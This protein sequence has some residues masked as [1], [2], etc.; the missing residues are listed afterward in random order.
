MKKSKK[1]LVAVS[2]G[3][4]LA[5]TLAACDN[6][7]GAS[8][9]PSG[10]SDG[11][12]Q[13]S[14]DG[15]VE[16]AN[17]T[18]RSYTSALATN[19]NP[20]AWETNA[21]S[22]ALSYLEEGFVSLQP[23]DTEK[24]IY[25]WAYDAATSIKDVT[26]DNAAK[27]A[28]YGIFDSTEAAQEYID[29]LDENDPGRYIYE[30]SLRD[31]LKWQDGTAI[32][33]Q[34]YID[35]MKYLLEPNSKNYRAN[36]Y[37]SGESAIA[38]GAD[39]YYQGSTVPLENYDGSDFIYVSS[40]DDIELKDGKYVSKE[41]GGTVYLAIDSSLTY[42]S[43][44]SLLD[45]VDSY[46]DEMFDTATF[47]QLAALANDDGL[48][49]L[50]TTSLA[51]MK[52][53]LNNSPEW[54]EDGSYW[55]CYAYVDVTYAAA[56][57][58]SVGIYKVDD[59]TFC[60]VMNTPLDESQTFV[61]FQETW[62]VHTE[63]Y[64]KLLDKSKTPWTST[65]GT[66][67]AT[68]MSYGPYKLTSLEA[69]KQMV[70]ETN[71]NWHGYEKVN[72][73]LVSYTNFEVDGAKVR[74]YQTTKVVI[75]QMDDAAAKQQFLKGQLTEYAPTS[76]ELSE[77]TLSDALYQVDE[78]Y[79]MSLF[80]NTNVEALQQMDKSEGNTNSV[81]LSSTNFRKAFSLGIDRAK[82]VTATPAY[83]PAYSLMN[84]LYYYDVW[85]DP[86]SSYRGSEPAMQAIVDL[87]GVEY[88][89]GKA[90]KTLEEAYNSING[91]NLTEAKKLM[92]S[93]CE[94]LV[95]AGLYT[96]GES[97]TIKMAYAK[98]A[99]QSDEQAQIAL[100]NQFINAA[101]EGSGFGAITLEGVGNLSD[102]YA[103]VPQG[104]YAIGYGAWGGAA[105]YPFR[106]MQVYCDPDSYDINEAADWNPKSETLTIEFDY[107]G[108]HFSDTMTWQ[109]WS[110]CLVGNGK[111]ATADNEIKL[112]ITATME[113]EFLGKYYRIPLCGSTSAFLLGYQV[114]YITE[115]YNIMY[116]FGGFR[117]MKYNYTDAEW[118]KYVSDNGG[119]IDYK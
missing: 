73:Q 101:A 106:N 44:Y 3:F 92:K 85:N 74:Q 100:L 17:Y 56:S 89:D 53:F 12:S 86:N 2:L 87:Y 67:V 13:S 104:K 115:N 24:G 47:D 23:S 102:R 80:F 52:T 75:N 99:L 77:Y 10:S 79:T 31:D 76:S 108:E 34:S 110:N 105:F 7:G 20:C 16:A 117:L 119:N 118:D 18:Y 28:Q 63:L 57:F 8:S 62:L 21:D 60:Y 68:T 58:D 83:K 61:S 48:V 29:G 81:V 88:G 97:I 38:G 32:N 15:T 1:S 39:Y 35:S 26:K 66:S 19:W 72:G 51:L 33:A 25:Q 71:E 5:T 6:G 78:T 46:G 69:E 109:A 43:G 37:V 65:Y 114:S 84:N 116:D 94:E 82:Y 54:G 91:Y 107:N 55:V 50:T 14:S 36:L 4:I 27:L 112:R 9:T 42:L 30:I 45:Y 93:A 22:S 95:A 90:Y 59:L 98:G 70:F 11:T 49:E 41:T 113:E 96:A 111:Y 64:E 40:D 103:A